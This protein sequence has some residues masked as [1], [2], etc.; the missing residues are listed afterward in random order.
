MFIEFHH[1]IVNVLRMV[2][3]AQAI[4]LPVDRFHRAGC[5]VKAIDARELMLRISSLQLMDRIYQQSYSKSDTR[6]EGKLD[7]QVQ[8]HI[9]QCT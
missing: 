4:Y 2:G 1:A 6:V 8:N 9:L 3:A 5:L 7:G